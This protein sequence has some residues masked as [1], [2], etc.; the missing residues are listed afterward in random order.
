MKKINKLA[1]DETG[2]APIIGV[3]LLIII[4]ALFITVIALLYYLPLITLGVLICGGTI[5]FLFNSKIEPKPAGIL[6][7]VGIIFA[8][9]G[10]L[11]IMGVF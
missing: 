8:S 9:I 6:F 5:F 2:I 4:I 3:I 11:Q 1:A 7:I 10:I